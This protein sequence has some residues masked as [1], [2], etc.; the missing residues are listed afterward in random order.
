MEKDRRSPL[1]RVVADLQG[2]RRVFVSKQG[3]LLTVSFV[4]NQPPAMP[5]AI[6]GK[7]TDFSPASRLRLLKFI[8]TVDWNA[9]K[10]GL[11]ITLT[12]PPNREKRTNKQRQIDRAQFIRDV[13][14]HLGHQVSGIWRIEWK[15]RKT[16][17]TKGQIA[18]H[19]HIFLLR[20]IFLHHKIVRKI[21]R[22]ILSVQGPL[23]TDVRAAWNAELASFYCAKY[24]TKL[25]EK[26]SLDNSAY[27]NKEGRHYGYI[28][29]AMIPMHKIQWITGFG[30][31]EID[32]LVRTGQDKLPWVDFAAPHTF[33]LLGRSAEDTFQELRK[34]V[35]D[36]TH[37]IRENA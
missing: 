28:R 31:E 13:E 10:N 5:I 29:K 6:R 32:F 3:K 2:K 36:R 26:C 19:F 7:V 23:A 17:I 18:P 30:E 34:L 9:T 27:H 35:L 12:Y 8:A 16:G 22:R 37:P 20:E 14:R 21:W 25:N 1:A 4:E 15:P 33:S 24:L 11:L